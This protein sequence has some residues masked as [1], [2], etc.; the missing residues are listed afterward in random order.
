MNIIVT[1]SS[2]QIG[3]YVVQE[4]VD[5]GHAVTGLDLRPVEGTPGDFLL[6]D[7]TK[8]GEIYNALARTGAEAVVH[9]GAWANAG[10]APDPRTYG[11]NTTGTFNLFQACADLGIRRIVSASSAQVYGFAGAP[12]LYAPVDEEHP[13]RP[14]N[15]YALSKTAG[16]QAAAYFVHNYGLEILSF[17]F[18]GVRPPQK[19][20]GEIEAM[21]QNPASGSWLLWTRTDARDAA[22]ACRLAIEA[23]Q[24]E[25]GPY[26]ITG[27]EVVLAAETQS[28]LE[29]HFGGQTEIRGDVSGRTSPLS[30]AKAQA[31]FGYQPRYVWNVAQQ[32]PEG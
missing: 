8:A 27:A 28:L 14:V 12:P 5:A 30:I 9:L 26:N 17:R 20:Q 15:C 11:E 2:G 16:E 21:A 31:A 25:S 4:F 10:V 13:V 24:V 22:R 3:R 18:M 6:V 23:A 1:G 32:H 7:L 29:K 19:I